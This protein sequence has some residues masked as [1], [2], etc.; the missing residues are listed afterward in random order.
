MK[1]SLGL[2]KLV[3]SCMLQSVSRASRSQSFSICF[4][5]MHFSQINVD[6]VVLQLKVRNPI[7]NSASL[8]GSNKVIL[9]LV[10]EGM[11]GDSVV[12]RVRFNGIILK[13]V[14]CVT[15]MICCSWIMWNLIQTA[16]LS[17]KDSYEPT[18]RSCEAGLVHGF[19]PTRHFWGRTG[20]KPFSRVAD[21][22]FWPLT[23]FYPNALR[24]P[25]ILVPNWL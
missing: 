5:L 3:W 18:I 24:W 10:L 4:A 20:R 22:W 23:L 1:L 2:K 11:K 8:Q 6:D 15:H 25:L 21:P 7:V 14:S 13:R 12:N 16:S 19:L 17:D 9:A